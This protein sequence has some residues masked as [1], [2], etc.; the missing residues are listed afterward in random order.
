MVNR[1]CPVVSG[2]RSRLI[3]E[4]DERLVKIALE[5]KEG[6]KAEVLPVL[7]SASAFFCSSVV[8]FELDIVDLFIRSCAGELNIVKS[9]VATDCS[10][11]KS[12]TSGYL[13]RLSGK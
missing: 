4:I 2:R 9:G 6:R 13:G 1:Q 5:E 12:E 10:E 8:D 11:G 7:G 3:A